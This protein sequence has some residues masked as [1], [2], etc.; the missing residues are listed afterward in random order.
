MELDR[1]PQ[2]Q[3][4]EKMPFDTR[5]DDQASPI[6]L[7][8]VAAQSTR[9]AAN[10]FQPAPKFATRLVALALAGVLGL[11]AALAAEA[12][13]VAG[14]DADLERLMQAMA[15]LKGIIAGALIAAMGWRLSIPTSPA[16]FTLFLVAAAAMTSG[17]GFMWRMSHLAETAVLLH[18]GLF[19][20]IFLLLRGRTIVEKIEQEIARRVRARDTA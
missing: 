16:R 18:A 6:V 11:A 10:L 4:G 20:A 17:I 1:E 7:E 12:S 8:P 2:N 14:A 19:G 5:N 3:K 13:P 9:R 15:A